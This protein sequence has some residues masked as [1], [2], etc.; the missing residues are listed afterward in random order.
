MKQTLF[1]N[2]Y[3]NTAENEEVFFGRWM[4]F[5]YATKIGKLFIA[6]LIRRKI[7]STMV[8]KFASSPISKT[9]ILPFVEKFKLKTDS[10]EKKI[11][12]FASF[13]EFFSRKLKPSARPISPKPNAISAP[14]DGRH[15]AYSSMQDFSP[16]FIKGERLT[17]EDLIVDGKITDKFIGGSILISR[18]SPA[19]YHRFHFPIAC[20]PEKTLLVNGRYGTVHPMAMAGKLDAFLRNKRMCTLLHS[21]VCGD[22]LMIEIG[23][24]CVGTIVQTFSPKMSAL[25]GEEKGYFEFGGSTVILIFEKGRIRF[26]EDVLENT[27]RGMETYVLMGDEIATIL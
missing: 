9:K 19:D 16:F 24:T 3:T 23:S 17:A 7:F 2:R 8:G 11:S 6:S 5:T 26:A 14:S 20:V 15:L 21:D 10:F 18:L 13:N 27:S 4:N 22:I 25:K 12:E 1:F